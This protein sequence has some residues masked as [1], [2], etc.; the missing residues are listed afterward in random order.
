MTLLENFLELGVWPKAEVINDNKPGTP[1]S[2]A[3]AGGSTVAVATTVMC[4]LPNI[5]QH[6]MQDE[7]AIED[8]EV[9]LLEKLNPE[10][11]V[12][13]DDTPGVPVFAVEA[14]GP[15]VT[16]EA[17]ASN[18]PDTAP[19]ANPAPYPYPTSDPYEVG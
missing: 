2:A 4:H 17:L 5:A 14:E 16:G 12:I 18:C 7:V 15:T 3:E 6:A 9:S 13:D 11:E 8:Q 10:A 19:A 1:G